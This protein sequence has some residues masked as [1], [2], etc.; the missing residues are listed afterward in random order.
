MP[1]IPIDDINGGSGSTHIDRTYYRT[2]V[3]KLEIPILSGIPLVSSTGMDTFCAWR[4]AGSPFN[5]SA[6]LEPSSVKGS[7]SAN[8]LNAIKT[9]GKTYT[10]IADWKI[11]EN[12]GF[13]TGTYTFLLT[14]EGDQSL[15]INFRTRKDYT[16]MACENIAIEV[17]SNKL[18]N[19]IDGVSIPDTFT[20]L[21]EK[22]RSETPLVTIKAV[23]L[24][25]GENTATSRYVAVDVETPSVYVNFLDVILSV[26][27]STLEMEYDFGDGFTKTNSFHYESSGIKTVLTRD[28]YG[29]YSSVD[30]E[31]FSV[32]SI[33]PNDFDNYAYFSKALPLRMVLRDGAGESCGGYYNDENSLGCEVEYT[34]ENY[35]D[36]QTLKD[37]WDTEMQFRSGYDI[38]TMTLYDT[39]GI[40]AGID[41]PIKLIKK[42]LNHTDKRPYL[43]IEM[44][45][46]SLIYFDDFGTIPTFYEAGREIVI[47][48]ENRTI[49]S[50]D[51]IDSEDI[52]AIRTLE[53]LLYDS[54]ELSYTYHREIYNIYE[55]VVPSKTLAHGEYFIE[56]VLERTTH[57]DDQFNV[58]VLYKS[59]RLLIQ[60]EFDKTID[61]LYWNDTNNDIHWKSDIKGL[62]TVQL[63]Y[64]K[65]VSDHINEI[66]KTDNSVYLKSSLASEKFEFLFAPMTTEMARKITYALSQYNVALNGTFYS[67]EEAAIESAG[68][69]SNLSVVKATGNKT[70]KNI[71]FVSYL[72]VF[73]W[74]SK[75]VKFGST[76]KFDATSIPK[77]K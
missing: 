42:N 76:T 33:D 62:L 19:E 47:G 60:K 59:L 1:V 18:F 56:A 15:P 7:H 55:F 5:S 35:E 32:P 50:I 63:D 64:R 57:P 67:F 77:L 25:F 51:Y 16:Q 44:Q 53:F 38:N 20:Y 31:V 22:G 58:T 75:Q 28:I 45:G 30:L 74:S 72:E 36:T 69:Y 46:Y 6:T 71:N 68:E 12:V 54:E 66:V 29:C 11:N 27:Q 9:D 70:N 2:S 3:L 49:I 34:S 24:A 65:P 17:Y 21:I 14:V 39:D 73:R 23:D 61:I 48:T 52:W 4:I 40:N 26:T 37:C 10:I 8:L 13:T 41:L 43:H